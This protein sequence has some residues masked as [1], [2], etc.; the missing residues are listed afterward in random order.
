MHD[1]I[2]ALSLHDSSVSARV[3]SL[4]LTVDPTCIS[5]HVSTCTAAPVCFPS[6][7]E[8]RMLKV[9]VRLPVSPERNSGFTSQV[10]EPPSSFIMSPRAGATQAHSP[11][12]SRAA[13]SP[14]NH[15]RRPCQPTAQTP[16]TAMSML[17]QSQRP[18]V[19][20]WRNNYT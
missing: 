2:L 8:V 14:R 13:A 18:Q 5:S 11:I 17:P 20:S 12:H 19:P 9:T 15:R 7:H 4:Q 16:P 10:M 1:P 3:W 6:A